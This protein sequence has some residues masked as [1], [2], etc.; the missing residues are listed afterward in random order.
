MAIS[1]LLAFCEYKCLFEGN[2]LRKYGNFF[3]NSKNQEIKRTTFLL[4]VELRVVAVAVSQR[5]S[6]KENQS[7]L[8]R[9][10]V[11]TNPQHQSQWFGHWLV[12]ILILLYVYS[13]LISNIENIKNIEN[14]IKFSNPP[15]FYKNVNIHIIGKIICVIFHTWKCLRILLWKCTWKML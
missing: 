12:A 5:I 3:T 8:S 15:I 7:K 1:F 14:V 11:K 6:Q 2:M 9:L 4:S 10:F 13:L